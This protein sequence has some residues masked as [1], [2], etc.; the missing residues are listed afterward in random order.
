MLELSRAHVF[1]LDEAF[2]KMDGKPIKVVYPDFSV[3]PVGASPSVPV[4]I[5]PRRDGRGAWSRA[6]CPSWLENRRTELP[7]GTGLAG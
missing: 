5:H 7:H 3:I 1:E 6:F 2:R 4:G